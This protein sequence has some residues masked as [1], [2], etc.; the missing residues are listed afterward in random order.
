MPEE[1]PNEPS[2]LEILAGGAEI[3]ALKIDKSI[4]KVKVRILDYDKLQSYGDL[5]LNRDETSI[6]ELLCGKSDHTNIYAMAGA[7]AHE[8]R[9]LDLMRETPF[10]KQ[11]EVETKLAK[12]HDEIAALD[13]R[14]RWGNTLTEESLGQVLQLGERLNAKRHGRFVARREA[15]TGRM[16]NQ[17][18]ASQDGNSS[19][20]SSSPSG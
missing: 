14:P 5:T 18:K 7:R 12:V 4:E 3:N 17:V 6:A 1:N 10:E 20:R 16:L 19:G 15:A 11:S 8:Q 9:L 2:E 13:S